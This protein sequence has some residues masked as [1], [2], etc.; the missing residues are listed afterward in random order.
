MIDIRTHSPAVAALRHRHAAAD[1]RAVTERDAAAETAARRDATQQ[2]QAALQHIAAAVQQQAQGRIA[3]I[4]SRCL[5]AVFGPD[6]YE[7]KIEFE[8]KRGKTEA[9]LL[10]VRDGLE[11]DPLTASGGGAVDVAAFALRLAGLMLSR[12]PL[13]RLLVLDEPWRFLSSDRRPALRRLVEQLAA[14]LDVQI[15]LVTHSPDFVIGRCV[16]IG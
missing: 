12:P 2:A 11:V 1:A 10:F 6:A 8:R 16:E 14:E 7:F 13:R 4:V 5:R 9:R 15:I 3:S